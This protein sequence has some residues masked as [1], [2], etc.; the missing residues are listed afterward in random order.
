[1]K[2][3]LLSFGIFASLLGQAQL[4]EGRIIYERNIQLPVRMFRTDDGSSAPQ[5]PRTRT[6]QFELLFGNNQSLWQYLPTANNEEAGTVT[7]RDG[8][9]VMVM[10]VGSNDVNYANLT[11]GLRVDQREV[12]DRNF[13]VTDSLRRNNWKLTEETK[14]VLTYTV[15]KAIGTNVVTRPRI[16]MENGE[17]KREMV[18]DTVKV[19]AW[20]TTEIPVSVGPEAGQLP[21]AILE[22][23][24]NNGQT[25]YRALEVSPKV[26]LSKIREPKDGKKVTQAEF[27]AERDKLMEE[28]RKNMPRGNLIRMN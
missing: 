27:V 8:G 2:Q 15:R 24:V 1:M 16:T 6:D 19:I 23:D 14:K 13:V 4:K 9:S 20:F 3:L 7:T 12:M 28:M 10:R 11:T 26:S 18:T 22:M 17:M 21:G 25:V 5:P